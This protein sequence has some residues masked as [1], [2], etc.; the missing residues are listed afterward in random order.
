ML[1]EKQRA[2]K[3]TLLQDL[4]SG[5]SVGIC[6]ALPSTFKVSISVSHAG[7]RYRGQAW[8]SRFQA[9]Q[10]AGQGW[11]SSPHRP[12]QPPPSA[13]APLLHPTQL[14]K[15]R[16]LSSA[17]DSALFSLIFMPQTH[18]AFSSLSS[19]AAPTGS[20]RPSW[21]LVRIGQKET[22]MHCWWECN[23][24]RPLWKTIWSFLKKRKTELQ[25]DLA[26]PLLGIYQN[27][28][29]TNSKSHPKVQSSTVYNCQDVEATCVHQQING[30]GRSSIKMC[31]Y[32][33]YRS[34]Y[35]Y[36]YRLPRW[37]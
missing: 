22:L 32:V 30:Y 6:C 34:I 13:T 23:L 29:N 10:L 19:Q 37:H 24:V 20:S 36:I 7:L 12:L 15:L 28:K 17:P 5:S 26:I 33:I 11:W 2:G 18:C 9:S 31:V 25:Y 35:I 16:E 14:C 4:S 3:R 1:K 8:I 27:P 21:L